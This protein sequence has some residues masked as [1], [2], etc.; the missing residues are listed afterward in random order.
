[1]KKKL[2]E[3]I[4]PIAINTKFFIVDNEQVLFM[5]SDNGIAEEEVAIWLNTPFFTSALIFLFNRVWED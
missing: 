1:M 5:L 2:K 4:K 3:K